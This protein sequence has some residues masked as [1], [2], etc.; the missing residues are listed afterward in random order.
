MK[1]KKFMMLLR[2]GYTSPN[3]FITAIK[4]GNYKCPEFLTK[5]CESCELCDSQRETYKYEHKPVSKNPSTPHKAQAT[6]IL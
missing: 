4:I 6:Y 5:N 1:K 2:R 3:S